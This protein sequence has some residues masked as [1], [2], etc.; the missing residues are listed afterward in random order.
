M[1]VALTFLLMTAGS[2]G[3]ATVDG[4]I[5]GAKELYGDITDSSVLAVTRAKLYFGELSSPGG[6]AT[7]SSV[8]LN[9]GQ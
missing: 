4:R 3:I 5:G 6:S 2:G 7:V 9:V 1:S 8:L